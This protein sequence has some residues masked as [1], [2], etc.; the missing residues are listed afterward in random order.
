VLEIFT[1]FYY[2][3]EESDDVI[4]GSTKTAQHSIENNSKN[5]KQCS[6]NLAPEMHITKET[7]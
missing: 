4:D 6:S 7:E 2:A 3:H 1:F 5:I